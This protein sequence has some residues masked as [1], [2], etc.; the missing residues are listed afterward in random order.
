MARRESD[1]AAIGSQAKGVSAPPSLTIDPLRGSIRR[2]GGDVGVC[3]PRYGST[4]IR[5]V[6][7]E[8]I[9]TIWPRVEELV[10]RA[11]ARADGRYG[12]ADVKASLIA[13]KRQLWV[14]WPA[15]DCLGITEI[16]R[17][18]Q[19]TRL[20]VFALAGRLPPDW[21]DVLRRLESWAKEIGCRAVELRG[22]KGWI[23]RLPDYRAG[24]IEMTKEI[25]P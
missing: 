3:Q 10:G 4:V 8:E 23:R 16:S 17:Y 18:P 5:G 25:E 15:C 12:L 7:P 13:R 19:Q 9:E 22:R 2:G 14:V 24:L 6:Q 11:L 1:P 20:T 21:R